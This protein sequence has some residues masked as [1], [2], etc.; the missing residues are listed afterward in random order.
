MIQKKFP[1]LTYLN[2]QIE[3]PTECLAQEK[4]ENPNKPLP[5]EIQNKGKISQTPFFKVGS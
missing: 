5:S 1:E 2:F 4:R 3:E